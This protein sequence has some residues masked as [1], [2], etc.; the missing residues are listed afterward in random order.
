MIV[1]LQET[2]SLFNL[3]DDDQET[4]FC[5]SGSHPSRTKR[6]AD[7]VQKVATQPLGF[8][9]SRLH[10]KS[11][12]ED[13]DTYSETMER[14]LVSLATKDTAPCEVVS[15]NLT[16]EER[17][18]QAFITNVKERLVEGTTRFY[19]ALKKHQ[20][21]TFADLYKAKMSITQSVEKT[22]KADRN[23]LQCLLKV[24]IAGRTVEMVNLLKHEL[25][26]FP[27]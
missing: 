27:Q 4:V 18:M 11:A 8:D 14:R 21:K 22:I 7:D 3:E 12:Q 9:V 13:G 5:R 2:R 1:H 16:A 24:V 20:L 25:S 17:D 19:Y 6:G 23:Q 15:D 10:S 26:P